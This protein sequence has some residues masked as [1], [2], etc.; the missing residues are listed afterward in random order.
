MAKDFNSSAA[1]DSWISGDGYDLQYTALLL[2]PGNFQSLRR[3]G[4]VM[5]S[6]AAD[7]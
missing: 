4:T 5:T 3:P 1:S 6:I 7:Y 2:P